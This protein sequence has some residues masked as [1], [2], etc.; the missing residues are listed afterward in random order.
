M[1]FGVLGGPTCIGEQR[2]HDVRAAVRCCEPLFLSQR[3]H[4]TVAALG[5]EVA[6]PG[7]SV[8]SETCAQ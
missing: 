1:W 5:E 3:T 2:L 7:R 8:L 6:G 4:P